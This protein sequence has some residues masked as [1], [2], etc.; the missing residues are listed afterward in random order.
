VEIDEDERRER[1][2]ESLAALADLSPA[3]PPTMHPS[4]DDE[5]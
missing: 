2:A 1:E 5:E 4:V 3:A